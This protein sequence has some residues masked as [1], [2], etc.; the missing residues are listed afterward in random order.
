VVFSVVVLGLAGLAFQIAR[1]STRATD[2]ALHL[3]ARL[4]AVDRATAVPFDS[5]ATLLRPDTVWSGAVRVIARFEVDS[6]TA[7]QRNVRIIT[8]TSV[9]GTHPDTLE[10]Q[11]GRIRYPIPLR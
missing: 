1:R 7:V 6:V 10:M 8:S 2:Q 5:L 9:P 4:A 3:A 11:R